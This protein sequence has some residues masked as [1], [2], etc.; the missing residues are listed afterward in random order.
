MDSLGF[1]GIHVLRII[2]DRQ[3]ATVDARMQSFDAAVK[4]LRKAGHFGNIAHR[5]PRL[6]QGLARPAGGNQLDT[7][8]RQGTG[9][10]H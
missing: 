9:Q 1:Q 8:A 4:N 6:L 10:I 5:Q 3:D 2:A 7:Q